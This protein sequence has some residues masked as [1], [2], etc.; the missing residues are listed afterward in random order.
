MLNLQD[1]VDAYINSNAEERGA[2]TAAQGTRSIHQETMVYGCVLQ[3]YNNQSTWQ[4]M[5]PYN[6]MYQQGAT[7]N[8]HGVYSIPPIHPYHFM[9]TQH[10]GISPLINTFMP[11][12]VK[13][14]TLSCLK[15]CHIVSIRS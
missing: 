6:M 1:M 2:S 12:P 4:S 13:N 7:V 5:Y 8:P 9:S 14:Y 11:K 3:P 15:F 10:Q